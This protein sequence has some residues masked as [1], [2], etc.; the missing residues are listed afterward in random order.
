MTYLASRL[1]KWCQT[2]EEISIDE[3]QNDPVMAELNFYPDEVGAL[4]EKRE[5]VEKIVQTMMLK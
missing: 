1:G 5:T 3:I 2:E 4:I